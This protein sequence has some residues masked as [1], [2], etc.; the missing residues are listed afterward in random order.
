MSLSRSASLL[1]KQ[2]RL[3]CQLPGLSAFYGHDDCNLL[4]AATF[5]SMIR[6][7]SHSTP[8]ARAPLCQLRR[9]PNASH[10]D[11]K[12]ANVCV[13]LTPDYGSTRNYMANKP[14][15]KARALPPPPSLHRQSMTHVE[16]ATL[17]EMAAA[18]QLGSKKKGWKNDVEKAAVNDE[19]CANDQDPSQNEARCT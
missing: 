7:P 9:N 15:A 1:R 12:T 8:E 10:S 13:P 6:A 14:T 5:S 3:G 11:K 18:Y 2:L 16:E 4:V 19:F 17:L